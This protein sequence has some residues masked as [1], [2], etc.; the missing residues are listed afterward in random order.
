MRFK[1]KY[2]IGDYVIFLD[3]GRNIGEIVGID[4]HFS[5]ETLQET[6]YRVRTKQI[7]SDI[8]EGIETVKEWDIV[9]RINK[10]AFEKA[11]AEKC[12]EYIAK[13]ENNERN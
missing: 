1:T 2:N 6:T 4:I 5:W 10:K 8:F 11:F 3:F 13:G 7:K 12:V 9:E